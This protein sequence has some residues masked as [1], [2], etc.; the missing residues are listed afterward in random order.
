MY[1]FYDIETDINLTNNNKPNCKYVIKKT[2][3]NNDKY[4]R[5]SDI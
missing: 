3:D 5:R 4:K 2:V 1:M